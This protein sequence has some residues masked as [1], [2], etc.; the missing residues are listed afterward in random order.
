LLIK[1]YTRIM[2]RGIVLMIMRQMLQKLRGETL[3]LDKWLDSPCDPDE[4]RTGPA[5][6]SERLLIRGSH[7][8]WSLDVD[9]P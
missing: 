6:R 8:P 5:N 4:R 9:G 1:S 7:E 2:I 3:H